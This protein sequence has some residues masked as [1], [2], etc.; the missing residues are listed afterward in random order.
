MGTRKGIRCDRCGSLERTRKLWLYIEQ[1]TIPSNGQILHIAPEPGLARALADLVPDGTYTPADYEPANFPAD[2]KVQKIDLCALDE[3][4]ANKYD[5]IVHCHVL[6]H[7]MCNYTYTLFQL[8]RMLKPSG[9]HVCVIPFLGGG[10]DETS[11]DI[12]VEE[13]TR[14]FGQFDHVRRFGRDDIPLHL[15]KALRLPDHHDATEEF[16]PAVLLDANIPRAAWAGWSPQTVLVLGKEDMTM[17]DMQPSATDAR[18]SHMTTISE[19]APTLSR[20]ASWRRRFVKDHLALHK[21]SILEIGALDNPTYLRELGDDAR[22]LDYFSTE[23]LHEKHRDSQRSVDRIVQVE[24]VV[25]SARPAEEVSE[26]FDLIV[27][28]HVVEHIPDLVHWF[29]QMEALLA[30]GGSLFLSV[31]DRQYTFDIFRP[32]TLATQLIRAH[33][34]DIER[35]DKWHIAEH[36]YYHQKVDVQALW[37]GEP[38]APFS[39]RMPLAQALDSAEKFASG[40]HDVHCWVFTP[41]SFKQCVSD[42]NS[43]GLTQLKIRASQDTAKDTNEFLVLLGR[44]P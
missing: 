4:P 5:L 12:G 19:A 39:P 10:F 41:E 31:P 36:L 34:A 3:Q 37:R 2:M 27:A 30:P 40:Y 15:G 1:L 13:R 29:N 8:H 22:Y 35:P 21:P 42:L 38:Q 24:Y 43:T 14:R 17:I 23:E 33:R 11:V 18:D 9:R 16:D 6:E 25:K 44:N 32:E 26:R 7:T 28:N 20:A